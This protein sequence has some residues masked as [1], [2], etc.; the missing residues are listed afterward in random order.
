MNMQFV[1]SNVPNAYFKY[2]Q[3]TQKTNS[4]GIFV[5]PIRQSVPSPA[6]LSK[7]QP[8]DNQPVVL[9]VKK[10]RWG[11]PTWFLFHTLAHKLN[12]ES[13]DLKKMDLLNVISSI[14]S[15]LPCPDCANHA[16]EY[17]KNINFYAIKTKQ[18][19][20]NMLFQ[21]HNVVNQR[22]GLT[23]FPIDDLDPKYSTA[24]TKTI[25][26]NF[27]Y[28]FQ[29]KHYSI[30]MIANDM[31]RAKIIVKLKGWFNDNIQYFDP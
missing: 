21:F 11:E 25:I 23:L 17:M 10:M 20:K 12:D 28:F 19:L 6:V 3:Q 9:S 30:R 16:S 13:F 2:I 22:K 1:N 24:N 14:C 27:M 5:M 7:T 31:Y 4:P 8:V 15:N 18:D 29:D 26:Q